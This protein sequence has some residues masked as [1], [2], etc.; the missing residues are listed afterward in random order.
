V[1]FASSTSS[2]ARARRVSAAYTAATMA[3]LRDDG[4]AMLTFM[5]ADK[6]RAESEM[7]LDLP[8]AEILRVAHKHGAT[9]VRVFGSR[10]RVTPHRIAISISSLGWIPNEACST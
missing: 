4:N 5:S 3:T 10:A 1:G 6:L 9:S 7:K 2:N 8:V